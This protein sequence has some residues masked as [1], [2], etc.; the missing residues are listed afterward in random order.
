MGV[1]VF[2]SYPQPHMQA[3]NAFIQALSEYLRQR[4]LGLPT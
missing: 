3:Q 1:P 4:N 2:L